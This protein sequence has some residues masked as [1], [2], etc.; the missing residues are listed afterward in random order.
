MCMLSSRGLTAPQPITWKGTAVLTERTDRRNTKVD[1][2]TWSERN[3]LQSSPDEEPP[4]LSIPV[5]KSLLPGERALASACR[6]AKGRGWQGRR[7]RLWLGPSKT[8]ACAKSIVWAC[9]LALEA[10]RAAIDISARSTF[11]TADL[12]SNAD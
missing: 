4:R 7:V 11:A 5:V 3:G 9:E 10:G 8:P 1:D 2:C 12:S 6:G